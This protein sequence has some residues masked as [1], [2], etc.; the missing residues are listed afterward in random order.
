MQAADNPIEQRC[1]QVAAEFLMP[2]E[3]FR[4]EWEKGP[5]PQRLARTFKV[6]PI[7]IGRRALDLGFWSK[8][9]F[10]AFYKRHLGI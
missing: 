2:E 9:G 4:D 5:N 3:F 7:V 6:S 10:F 1:D 8:A